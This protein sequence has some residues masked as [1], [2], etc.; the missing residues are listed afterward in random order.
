[1]TRE[2]LIFIGLAIVVMAIVFFVLLRNRTDVDTA[3]QQ[4]TAVDN[5]QAGKLARL[6][7]RAGTT[8]PTSAEQSELFDDALHNPDFQIRISS[9]EIF[10]H[11]I[12]RE[13][14]IDVLIAVLRERES[15][16]SGG[17]N[18]PLYAASILADMNATRAIPDLT[19]WV[20][21]LET[22]R[23]HEDSMRSSMLDQSKDFLKRLKDS[24]TTQP[25]SKES[26][27]MFIAP[28]QSS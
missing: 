15:P 23:P 24:A 19:D 17:G 16:T 13:K 12:N 7:V 20:Q 27:A 4:P 28:V 6:L 2:R 11:V 3:A 18:V 9:M 8:P 22:H 14:A 1:M 26:A 25:A 10:P 5:S 21:Y